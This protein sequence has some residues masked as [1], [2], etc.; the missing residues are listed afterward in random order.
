MLELNVVPKNIIFAKVYLFLLLP[1]YFL[2][3]NTGGSP[4]FSTAQE[5]TK[6]MNYKDKRERSSTYRFEDGYTADYTMSFIYVILLLKWKTKG[7]II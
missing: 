1:L 4:V 5:N 6:S 3:N 7:L 2:L